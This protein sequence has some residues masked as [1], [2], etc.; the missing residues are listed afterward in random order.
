M[1]IAWLRKILN[2]EQKSRDL[3]VHRLHTLRYEDLCM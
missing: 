1:I 3:S 2:K